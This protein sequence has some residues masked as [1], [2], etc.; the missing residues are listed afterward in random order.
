MSGVV[1]D[2]DVLLLDVVVAEVMVCDLKVG[3]IPP[4]LPKSPLNL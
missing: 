4:Q 3:Q 1:E 2:V